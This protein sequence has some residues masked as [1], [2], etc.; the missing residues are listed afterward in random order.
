M[1]LTLRSSLPSDVKE[2]REET[3]GKK[4]ERL[5][6]PSLNHDVVPFPLCLL[7][8]REKEM[9]LQEIRSGFEF[10]PGLFGIV[11]RGGYL[12]GAWPRTV[13]ILVEFKFIVT[14]L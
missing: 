12:Y 4:C 8:I 11:L 14:E 5:M 1:T 6:L 13:L 2:G 3:H 9:S 10:V 7:S